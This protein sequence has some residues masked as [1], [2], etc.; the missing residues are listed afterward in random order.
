[1]KT[2]LHKCGKNG[3]MKLAEFLSVSVFALCT[4][5]HFLAAIL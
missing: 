1:M 5:E 3:K 4:S 2:L